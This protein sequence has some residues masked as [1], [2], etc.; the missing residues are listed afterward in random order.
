[1]RG[2]NEL[3][4]FGHGDPTQR[5]AS[6]TR[7]KAKMLVFIVAG[8]CLLIGGLDVGLY[9]VKMDHDHLPVSILRCIWLSIPLVA[10]IALLVKT[11]ALADWIENWL[12][13]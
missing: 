10:G 7:G 12:D 5:P 9:L 1:M 11:S 13:Q 4:P 6:S 3:D 8:G 2:D